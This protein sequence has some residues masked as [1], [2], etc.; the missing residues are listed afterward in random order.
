M[1]AKVAGRAEKVVVRVDLPQKV[2]AV[3]DVDPADLPPKGEAVK[4]APVVKV[5]NVPV[6]PSNSRD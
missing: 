4:V 5:E 2:E 6:G 3:R 1:A